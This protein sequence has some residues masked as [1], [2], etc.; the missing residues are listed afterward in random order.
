MKNGQI[1]IIKTS[2]FLKWHQTLF[3]ELVV[4]VC[5]FSPVMVWT[6]ELEAEAEL[7]TAEYMQSAFQVSLSLLQWAFTISF[8]WKRFQPVPPLTSSFSV[9]FFSLWLRAASC[10]IGK[11]VN[12][13]HLLFGS[14]QTNFL[15]IWK[16]NIKEISYLKIWGYGADGRTASPVWRI[17][18]KRLG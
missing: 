3:P 16:E 13:S 5:L 6:E 14:T 18:L 8:F 4:H 7:S 9:I 17:C 10:W 2:V 11:Q 1:Q 12:K 15:I